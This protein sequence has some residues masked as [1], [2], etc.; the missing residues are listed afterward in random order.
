MNKIYYDGQPISQ[1][2]SD[3]LFGLGAIDIN[4][5]N[6]K[7][8]LNIVLCRPDGEEIAI[9]DE[10]YNVVLN[11]YINAVDEIEFELPFYIDS[12][13]TQIKNYNWDET[14]DYLYLK[15]NN[16]IMFVINHVS[17]V[18][19]NTNIKHIYAYSREI[20]LSKR[21]LAIL[22]GTRQLYHDGSETTVCTIKYSLNGNVWNIYNKPFTVQEGKNIFIKLYDNSNQLLNEYIWSAGDKYQQFD[23]V[24]VTYTITDVFNKQIEV[25]MK[26]ISETG[27][28]ILNIL[29]DETAWRIGY[30]DPEVR[31]DRSKGQN[32]RK[33]RTFNIRRGVWLEILYK[34]ITELFDCIIDVDTINQIFN[35]YSIDNF[36]RNKGLYISKDNYLKHIKRDTTNDEIITR[37]RVYGK[38]N[39]SI[40]SVNPLGTE[41]IEDFSYYRNTKYMPYDLLDALDSYDILLKDEYPKFYNYL[42]ELKTLQEKEIEVNNQI[43]DLEMQKIQKEDVKDVEIQHATHHIQ[44]S[45]STGDGVRIDDGIDIDFSDIHAVDLSECNTQIKEVQLSIVNKKNELEQLNEGIK[46]KR[47]QIQELQTALTK[48]NNFT[49]QQLK[50]LD[51]FIKE[52][53]WENKNIDDV[54]ELYSAGIKTLAKLSKPLIQFEIE[55][56]DFLNITECQKDWDKINLGDIVNIYY[57]DFDLCVEAKIVKISHNI[58]NGELQLTISNK[59][60]LNDD[61]KYLSDIAK[62]ANDANNTIDVFKHKWD[63]S[64]QNTDLISQIMNNA[65]DSSKNRILSARNQNIKIDER[66]IQMKDMFDDNEQLRMI[67]NCIAMTKDGWNSCSLAITPSGICAEQIYG[68]VIGS[69]KLIITNMNDKGESSFLVDG[70]HMKAINMDLSLLRKNLLNRI[71]MNPEVG[72][73]IQK[74]DTKNSDWQDLLWL[75]MNGEIYAKSFHV[76]NTNTELNDKGLVVDNGKIKIMNKNKQD[77]FYTDENGEMRLDGRL[78]VIRHLEQWEAKDK[79]DIEPEIN[80]VIL[81]DAYK[82]NDKGGKLLVNDWN[83]N[84]NVFLGSP[85]SDLYSGGFVKIFSGINTDKV[86]KGEINENDNSRERIELGILKKEDAGIINIR[87]KEVKRIISMFGNDNSGE[88]SINNNNENKIISLTSNDKGGIIY[89]N[90]QTEGVANVCLGAVNSDFFGYDG[91]FLQLFN[92]SPLKKRL[93]LGIKHAEDA[94]TIEVYGSNNKPNVFLSALDNDNDGQSSGVIKLLNTQG[95]PAITLTSDTNKNPMHR[96]GISQMVFGEDI[97]NPRLAFY[98]GNGEYGSYIQMGD[99]QGRPQ[100]FIGNVSKEEIPGGCQVWYA[101]MSEFSD[102]RE[103]KRIQIYVN[104]NSN[105]QI[106]FWDTTQTDAL[107]ALACIKTGE[108]RLEIHHMSGRQITFTND[109]KIL[110]D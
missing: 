28:G 59:K 4:K 21:L 37:L 93:F 88:I 52:G 12:Q 102:T 54:H 94:G 3:E 9:L 77:A 81:L 26:I 69:N 103:S 39:L 61:I 66:G 71:Y 23:G 44:Y 70:S 31:E 48:E 15:V 17:D 27:N 99:K 16:E 56:V 36:C 11:L 45:E 55:I 51:G 68:K 63:L 79:W 34:Q 14:K 109:G 85:P 65:L 1:Q 46:L 32:H 29:E 76:I 19:E 49:K 64:G 72:F 83:G 20:L 13:Y 24:D 100:M 30:I 105:A 73:K 33:Y 90:G 87:N 5:P 82:D 57:D 25:S 58:T 110:F 74:R 6:S 80:R 108:G 38:D 43:I 95:Q 47:Q 96:S 40:A 35:I 104:N 98:S 62:M 101:N 75:D 10:A 53:T 67:N 50:I 106:D 2:K 91:G 7:D 97:K 84:T 107:K 78:R 92:Q 86:S 8:N 60:E 22:Q 42:Q 18:G 89:V 41:Y